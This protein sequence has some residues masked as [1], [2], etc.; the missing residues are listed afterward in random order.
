MQAKIGGFLQNISD[1]E[2]N[3]IASAMIHMDQLN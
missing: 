2:L 1:E 3:T